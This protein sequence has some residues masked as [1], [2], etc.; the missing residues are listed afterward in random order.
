MTCEKKCGEGAIARDPTCTKIVTKKK[1]HI[2]HRNDKIPDT[3]IGL[4]WV[5][6]VVHHVTFDVP[7]NSLLL[8]LRFGKVAQKRTSVSALKQ[9]N[10]EAKSFQKVGDGLTNGWTDQTTNQPTDQLTNRPTNQPTNQPTDQPTNQP[11]DQ[12]TNQRTYLNWL[13][14][15]SVD[16]DWP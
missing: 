15:I 4:G 5:G 1:S 9:I 12:P 8:S 2:W 16:C 3:R 10:K 13:K 11:T 14:L 7:P 6:S